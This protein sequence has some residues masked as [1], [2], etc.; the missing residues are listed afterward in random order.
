M[1]RYSE[2]IYNDSLLN[3]GIIRIGTLHDFRNK[4]KHK[5][6]VAD[7]M[8][9]AKT[10]RSSFVESKTFN[11]S[12]K[13][14]DDMLRYFGIKSA[15]GTRHTFTN[16]KLERNHHHPNCFILCASSICSLETMRE[17][18]GND[19]CVEIFDKYGFYKTLTETLYKI[20]P[21][22]FYGIHEIKY[23]SRIEPYSSQLHLSYQYDTSLA[24]I[25]D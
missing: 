9:G 19:S 21:V 5:I 11:T 4:E 17:F 3:M 2:K 22:K 14:S 13:N 23:Q 25:K 8:E 10:I 7:E 16:S 15:A 20:T 24:L 1:Y 18:K 6:G 12:D